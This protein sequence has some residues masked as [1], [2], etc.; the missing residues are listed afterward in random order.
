[1]LAAEKN[2]AQQNEQCHTGAAIM[3]SIRKKKNKIPITI[4]NKTKNNARRN[5]KIFQRL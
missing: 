1:M 5:S 3:G 4:T 2:A